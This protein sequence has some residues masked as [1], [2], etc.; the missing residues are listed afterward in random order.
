MEKRWW[1]VGIAELQFIS[2]WKSNNV[3]THLV[4]SLPSGMANYTKMIAYLDGFSRHL[5]V[6]KKDR[7]AARLHHP[8]FC[9]S[10]RKLYVQ[11]YLHV[12]VDEIEPANRPFNRVFLLGIEVIGETM[13]SLCK[14][15]DYERNQHAWQ[16]KSAIHSA[17]GQESCS[18]DPRRRIRKFQHPAL[19]S[20]PSVPSRV[21]C[22]KPGHQS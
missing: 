17:R 21:L 8:G 11:N 2:G 19:P 9:F 22:R 16:D 10:R 6:A 20:R 13:V 15:A 1:L 7:Y 3:G 4:D 18:V 5:A 12:W 14:R